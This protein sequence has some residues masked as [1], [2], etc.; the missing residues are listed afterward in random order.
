[1]AILHLG[2]SWMKRPKSGYGH[3]LFVRVPRS[4]SASRKP[5]FKSTVYGV[6]F[7]VFSCMKEL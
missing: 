7:L 3:T 5:G 2:P 1:M 4:P 6:V